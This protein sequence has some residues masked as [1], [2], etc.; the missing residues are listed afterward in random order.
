MLKSEDAASLTAAH[1]FDF[2]IHLL[3]LLCNYFCKP[4]K[5]LPGRCHVFKEGNDRYN[6]PN[7]TETR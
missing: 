5:L 4:G 7:T 3:K 1:L 2:N 6:G